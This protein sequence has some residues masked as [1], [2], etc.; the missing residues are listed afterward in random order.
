MVFIMCTGSRE[1]T[2]SDVSA[3]VIQAMIK[4]ILTGKPNRQRR[5]ALCRVDFFASMCRQNVNDLLEFSARLFMPHIG[6]CCAYKAARE[7]TDMDI[8]L[9]L[10]SRETS[11]DNSDDIE[12]WKEVT[13]LA[14]FGISHQIN[15]AAM[16]P[17]F[18]ALGEDMLEKIIA[19]ITTCELDNSVIEL[20]ESGS[21]S[22]KS[23]AKLSS[24]HYLSLGRSRS[25]AMSVHIQVRSN[26]EA[27]SRTFNLGNEKYSV[28]HVGIT[29]STF[30]GSDVVSF[31]T[32]SLDE[33]VIVCGGGYEWSDFISA[34]DVNRFSPKSGPKTYTF[35]IRSSMSELEGCCTALRAFYAARTNTP[36]ENVC[37][38]EVWRF[39]RSNGR[40]DWAEM[41]R[42]LICKGFDSAENYFPYS[43]WPS[44][45]CLEIQDIISSDDL[46][47]GK[48]EV[49]VLQAVIRWAKSKC[50]SPDDHAPRVG[51]L[52]RVSYK[53]QD[54][55]W[56]GAYCIVKHVDSDSKTLRIEWHDREKIRQEWAHH[57][58]YRDHR[59][60]STAR[61]L[62]VSF[63]HVY[64]V[65]ETGML[66][67]LPRIRSDYIPIKHLQTALLHDEVAYALLHDTYHDLVRH[68]VRV[69]SPSTNSGQC[70]TNRNIQPS[71]SLEI[72]ETGKPRHGYGPAGKDDVCEALS[73]VLLRKESPAQGNDGGF[74]SAVSQPRAGKTPRKRDTDAAPTLSS[75]ACDGNVEGESAQCSD[76]RKKRARRNARN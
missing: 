53:C 58:R 38:S 33:C 2:F 57:D 64:T 29:A 18:Q 44:L 43:F 46:C 69:R 23:G 22:E 70:Q 8:L 54:N 52:V 11:Y 72:F 36:T 15:K 45:T 32:Q 76:A 74:G 37:M 30:R 39:C 49:R 14:L 21:G 56:W 50:D 17:G 12:Q 59:L 10:L 42:K 40:S 1:V 5:E 9:D 3:E 28:L 55:L 51:S 65:A 4:G 16:L 6:V 66:R 60:N 41:C 25:G 61:E 34:S 68:I 48:K 63:D 71:Q 67:L 47:T 75:Q 19:L 13:K 73:S 62:Q 35:R 31:P 7:T 24:G 26:A 20:T 27:S